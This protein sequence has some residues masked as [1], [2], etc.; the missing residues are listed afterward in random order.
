MKASDQFGRIS[1]LFPWN[2]WA[3]VRLHFYFMWL[4]L[5]AYFNVEVFKRQIKIYFR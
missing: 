3:P 4:K 1:V 2:G 5:N